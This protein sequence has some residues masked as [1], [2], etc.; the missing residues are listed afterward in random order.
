MTD[1]TVGTLVSIVSVLKKPTCERGYLSPRQGA[2]PGGQVSRFIAPLGWG[3]ANAPNWPTVSGTGVLPLVRVVT[4]GT[5]VSLGI[6]GMSR[7]KNWDIWDMY[8]E[9]LSSFV[10][11]F[12]QMVL[13]LAAYKLREYRNES[14]Q[15]SSNGAFFTYSASC[16][17]ELFVRVQATGNP[18]VGPGSA[19]LSLA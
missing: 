1:V 13:S 3:E 11:G 18:V 14:S 19:L 2:L 16:P 15:I 12:Y 5:A 6:A 17:T 7:S 4:V 8:Q 9:K 10:T